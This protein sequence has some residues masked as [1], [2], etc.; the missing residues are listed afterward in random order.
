MC[1]ECRGDR[2]LGHTSVVFV[3]MD[4]S[5]NASEFWVTGLVVPEAEAI[6]LEATLDEVVDEAHFDYGVPRGAELHGNDLMNGKKDWAKLDGLFRARFGVFLGAL[7][8][9]RQTPGIQAFTCGMDIKAQERRYSYPTPPRQVLVGHVAQRCHKLLSSGEVL[10]LFVDDNPTKNGIRDHVR[11]F[12]RH[13]TWSIYN[14]SPLKNILD[15]VYFAPF[16]DS[17]LLQAADLV[18]Y[19]HFRAHTVRSTS[20]SYNASHQAWRIVQPICNV[21]LWTP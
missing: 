17:R 20:R 8:A 15:T 7:T 21:H 19:A 6:N 9:I 10:G 11:H 13:G 16:C 14:S 12:K 18:S 3:Y 1:S 4:E 2:P 5:F